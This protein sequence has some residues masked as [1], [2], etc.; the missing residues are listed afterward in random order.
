MSWP[1]W[2]QQTSAWP[3]RLLSPLGRAVCGIARQ[4]RRRFE[5][6][7]MPALPTAVIVVVG[8]VT[9]G[10][11]GKTPLIMRLG[12]ALAEAGIAYGIVSRGYGGKAAD[13]PL[14]VTSDC[15]PGICGDEPCLLA[16]RLGVPIVVAPHRM[17]AVT[18]LLQTHPHVQVILS[19]DGLQHVALPR[20]LEVV[21]ADGR[22]GFGNGRCMPA[23]PLR[24]PLAVLDT[25]DFRICNGQP[26]DPRL[27]GWPVMQLKP[28][29]WLN[30]R[31]ERLSLD[32]FC[33]QPIQAL[34]GIGDPQRFFD[35]L[36]ALGI[37]LMQTVA[38]PDHAT[39]DLVEKT[40]ASGGIWLMTEK[41][42]IKCPDRDNVWALVV[43][44]ELPSAWMADW[45][46]AVKTRL[47]V[48]YE[49]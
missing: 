5:Q 21:V 30:G 25:V 16:R 28:Q 7:F 14:A 6:A 29:Y 8:N 12:E 33:G 9:V 20:D 32:A 23:G 46:D 47:K 24:E 22:R 49:P 43:R 38:L 34:A 10:G 13:Y 44:S 35:Q 17:A 2:W 3:T 15:D 40:V 45:L 31:G 1:G 42:A 37:E 41:D 19:D 4:R 39:P 48:K 36:E 18:H 11:S 27:A 26:R